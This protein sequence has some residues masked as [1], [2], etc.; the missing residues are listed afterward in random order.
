MPK[1]REVFLV[2]EGDPLLTVRHSD[3]VGVATG[4]S[5]APGVGT[6]LVEDATPEE[7]A[8]PDTL[9]DDL[10]GRSDLVELPLGA[11]DQRE[12]MDGDTWGVFWPSPVLV[13]EPCRVVATLP[14]GP[15]TW[16]APEPLPDPGSGLSFLRK[17]GNGLVFNLTGDHDADLVLAEGL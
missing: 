3:W 14:Q 15:F 16:S 10:E 2:L 11:G 7:T 9:R 1:G 4:P 8:P 13:A 12:A 6:W 17:S 5:V